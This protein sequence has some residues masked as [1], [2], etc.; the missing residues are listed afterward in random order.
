MRRKNVIENGAGR[1][2]AAVLVVALV[3]PEAASADTLLS[4]DAYRKIF[5][6]AIESALASHPGS[7]VCLP[8]LS[9]TGEQADELELNQRQVETLSNLP[10]ALPAQMKALEEQGLVAGFS[11]ERTVAGKPEIIRKYKRTEKGN[12]YY[13]ER[14]LCYARA[15]LDRIVKWRG[16]G[17]FGA[18]QFALVEYTVKT[19]DVAE[20]AMSPAVQTAFPAIKAAIGGDTP[21][22]RQAI[23]DLTSEGWEVNEWS[24]AL[25]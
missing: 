11:V 5:T 17:V 16:P 3:F 23:V 14:R 15:R 13:S 10:T 2:A 8:V 22:I 25:E 1:F 20:W 19:N 18:Y 21:K 12:R 4:K 7:N 24:K 6:G 9:W